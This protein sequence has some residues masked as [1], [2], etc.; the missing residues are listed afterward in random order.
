MIPSIYQQRNIK[1]LSN[2]VQKELMQEEVILAA[3]SNSEFQSFLVRQAFVVEW[4]MQRSDSKEIS[5]T[6]TKTGAVQVSQS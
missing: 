5:K 4:Q 2:G 1:A 3:V 6:T